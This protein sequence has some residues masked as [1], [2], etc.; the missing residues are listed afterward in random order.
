MFMS[1]AALAIALQGMPALAPDNPHPLAPSNP[2]TA[3]TAIRRHAA[4]AMISMSGMA[5]A[6][7][8]VRC[9]RNFNRAAIIP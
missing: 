6:T 9:R 8:T 4:T 7:A 3:A 2:L 1:M 5:S